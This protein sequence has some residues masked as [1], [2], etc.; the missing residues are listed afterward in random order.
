M[1]TIYL[2]P[3]LCFRVRRRSRQF[4]WF[5]V[6]S[7]VWSTP[8]SSNTSCSTTPHYFT[9]WCPSKISVTHG[10][11]SPLVSCEES[12]A[13]LHFGDMKGNFC[14]F[15]YSWLICRKTGTFKSCTAEGERLNSALDKVCSAQHWAG[16]STGIHI[17]T[18]QIIISSTNKEAF[19]LEKGSQTTT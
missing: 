18:G 1:N 9:P 8:C 7:C 2:F 3:F 12:T 4:L 6:T 15:C 10:A 17:H 11:L 14:Y 13:Q 16:N 19:L 5:Q